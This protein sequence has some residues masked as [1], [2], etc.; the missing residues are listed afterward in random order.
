MP[1]PT[2]TS[3]QNYSF[4]AGVALIVIGGIFMLRNFDMIDLGHNWWAW[5][6][7][8]PLAYTLSSAF[9]RRRES[10]GTFPPEARGS[11]IGAAVLALVMCIFLFDLNWGAMWPVFLILGGLSVILG[12][13]S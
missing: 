3:Q 8:I 11:L 12:A 10:G 7:L 4:I 5:F 1:Q 9:K 13:R 6:M 2:Q